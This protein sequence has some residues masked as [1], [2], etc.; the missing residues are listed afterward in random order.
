MAYQLLQRPYKFSFSKNPIRYQFNITNPNAP[1]SALDVQLYG[2]GI[3]ETLNASQLIYNT[4]LYPNP[5]GSINFDCED[6]LDSFTDWQLPD[7]GNDNVQSITSQIKKFYV[8]YRQITKDNPSPAWVTDEYDVRIVIKGGIAKEKWDRNNFFI[9]Y[10]PTAKPFMTWIPDGHFI[11]TEER[12][13]LTYFHDDVAAPALYLKAR[14]VYTD[15]AEDTVTKNFPSLNDTL[16]FHVPAGLQQLGLY[17]L[18]PTKKIWYYDVWVEDGSNNIY[19]KT[20]RVYA[21]YR[22]YYDVFSFIYHTSLGGMDT[23]RIRGDYDVEIVL[24][25]TEIQ[26][27]TG[28][29][30][31]MAKLPTENATVN[32][33]KYEKYTGDAGWMN[34]QRQQDA[35]QDM[36]LSDGV[37]RVINNKWLRVVNLAK[38]QVMGGK[39]DTKWSFPLQWRYTYDN[40]QYTPANLDFGPGTNAEAPGLVYGMCTAPNNLMVVF[41]GDVAGG[42][43]Y[44][45]SWDPVADGIGYELELTLAGVVKANQTPVGNSVDIVIADGGAYN[46]RLRTKCGPEDYSGYTNGPG[47]DVVFAATVCTAP[48]NLDVILMNIDVNNA[49]VKFTWP[50]V[51][52]VVGYIIEWREYG[53]TAWFAQFVAGTN[54][55]TNLKPNVQYERRVKS[56]CNNT[57]DYSGYTYGDPFIPSNM[58]GSCN[59]PNGLAAQI[60]A[61]G[62]FGQRIVELRWNAA[63]SAASYQAQYREQGALNWIIKDNITDVKT[64]TDFLP[65]GKTYEW[66]VRTNCTGS[67]F[68]NFVNGP[69]FNT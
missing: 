64:F 34:T 3:N 54:Y 52:G 14:V 63:D 53:A 48:S 44:T 9:N 33:S 61:S 39:S 21:D 13:Y 59:P 15:G 23:L 18:Q 60:I 67:G 65:S 35:C 40:S 24:S 45:F 5:D 26:Q 68:S 50:A 25:N 42:K 51:A 41:V 58:I 29:D 19:A 36:L 6:Y 38:S 37:Y 2:Y 20:Y 10:M 46:W 47:F 69:D 1:G 62:F 12:R 22:K 49:S 66:R 7:L 57:P 28:G 32:I 17:A 55:T 30:F 8:K 31:S 56:Q 4:T 16:L 43:K 27:A 11:G